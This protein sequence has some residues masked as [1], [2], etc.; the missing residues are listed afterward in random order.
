METFRQAPRNAVRHSSPESLEPILGQLM[1]AEEYAHM[2][3]DRPYIFKIK[4]GQKKLNYFGAAHGS[5][6]SDEQFNQIEHAFQEADPDIVFVEGVHVSGDIARFNNYV[7]NQSRNVAIEE[8]GEPRFTLKLAIQKGIEWRSPE[9]QEEEMYNFLIEKGYTKDEIFAWCVF[10]L[11][12]QYSW[13]TK[14][15][16]FEKFV[17]SYIERFK[18]ATRWEGFIYS[19]ENALRLGEQIL[20]RKIDV[21]NVV[22]PADII[23]PIPWPEMKDT[24]TVLNRINETTGQFRDRKIVMAIAEALKSHDKVFVVY[25]SSHAVMQEPALRALLGTFKDEADI[26][27]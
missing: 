9:P 27:L 16:A 10:R 25:G 24:Q 19:Y 2:S 21:E 18:G 5:D 20:G 15:D 4:N 6:P 12:P 26:K 7:A 8:G 17:E 22:A 14:R 11:L 23:D 3:H 1:T 13:Q